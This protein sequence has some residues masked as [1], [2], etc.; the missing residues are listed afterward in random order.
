MSQK[1]NV[2]SSNVKFSDFSFVDPWVCYT[3]PYGKAP[4]DFGNGFIAGL[5]YFWY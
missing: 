1:W 3:F 4:T 2:K 5:W